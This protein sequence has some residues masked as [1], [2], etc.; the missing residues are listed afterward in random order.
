M[1]I[2]IEGYKALNENV[3]GLIHSSS[4]TTPDTPPQKKKDTLTKPPNW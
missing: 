1:N 3:L 2:T 4:Q